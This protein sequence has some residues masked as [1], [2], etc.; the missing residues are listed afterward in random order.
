M[1]AHETP[2]DV[3]ESVTPQL[4]VERAKAMR[5]MLRAQQ[6]E[7][8]A[9]GHY[10]PEVHRAFL[11]AGFYDLLTPKRFGGL[12]FGLP[13]F[14]EVIS[15]IGRGD[16]SAAW[17]LGLG[18]GHTLTLASYWPEQAQEEIFN[19]PLGYFRSNHRF[20]PMGTARPVAGG[21]IVN[22]TWD[23]CSGIQYASHFK[24]TARVEAEGQPPRQVVVVI[25][26]G[27]Y[28]VLDDWGGDRILGMRASG[29]NSVKVEDVFVPE[30][31]VVTMDWRPG[32]RADDEGPAQGVEIHGNPMYNGRI[33]LHYMLELTA[34][35][36]GAALAALD[37]FETILLTKT[38]ITSPKV[39]RAEDPNSQR[40]FG[41][42]TGLSDS[43]RGLMLWAAQQY[44]EYSQEWADGDPFTIEKD[45]RLRT[46][47]MQ[48]GF[49]ACE[50]VEKAFATASTSSAKRG[51]PMERYFRDVAMYRGHNGT[52][53]LN[54]APSVAKAHFGLLQT[55]SVIS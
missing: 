21:Y 34:P 2:T 17:C 14:A 49:T 10:G 22:G 39:R 29:S 15:E 5:P 27:Q 23:Y 7:A 48:A 26:A 43:A 46:V 42:V 37:E 12:E 16:P 32:D 55:T 53:Y 30:H 3:S 52:Q 54:A 45:I 20:V 13:T 18:I 44:M 4:L 33:R 47:M 19:N 41:L 51:Q 40:D 31:W 1:T 38:T 8:E 9:L 25:P 24:A 28:T 36:V 6:A 35:V 11:E 50:A